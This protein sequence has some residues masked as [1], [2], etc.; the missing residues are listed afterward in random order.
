MPGLWY[1]YPTF[2][3]LFGFYVLGTQVI[4]IILSSHPQYL[5]TPTVVIIMCGSDSLP[6]LSVRVLQCK[7]NFDFLLVYTRSTS[8][9]TCSRCRTHFWVTALSLK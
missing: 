8:L 2:L 3:P 4:R 9:Q 6:V 5:L 1:V 7:F